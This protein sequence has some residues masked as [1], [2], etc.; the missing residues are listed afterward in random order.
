MTVMTV[1]PYYPHIS[2]GFVMGLSGAAQLNQ[3]QGIHTA[4]L[5]K[6]AAAFSFM[7][8]E[9]FILAVV[10]IVAAYMESREGRR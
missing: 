5:D 9:A 6:F 4:T 7:S 10:G 1:I 3:L 2:K 8:L